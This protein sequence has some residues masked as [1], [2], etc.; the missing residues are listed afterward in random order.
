MKR[1]RIWEFGM[2]FKFYFKSNIFSGLTRLPL[3]MSL[4]TRGLM[5][6]SPPRKVKGAAQVVIIM[7]KVEEMQKRGGKL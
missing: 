2:A 5:P 4:I 1:G 6:I 3:A 7:N